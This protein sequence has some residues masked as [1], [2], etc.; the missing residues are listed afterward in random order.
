MNMADIRQLQ[1][2]SDYD[3][4]FVT[5]DTH[6]QF[7][8]L[9]LSAICAGIT[10]NDLLIILGDVGVNID[11]GERDTFAKAK[12]SQIQCDI[13]CIHGN[14]E[15]RPTTPDI[16]WKYQE[17]QWHDGIIYVEENYKRILFAKDGCRF[18]ING[19]EFLV[20]GGAYSV[21][22]KLRL[23]NGFPWFPD[24]Q[25]TDREKQ[26]IT[27]IVDAHGCKEDVILAHTCPYNYRPF[28]RL[29][30]EYSTSG[31]DTSMEQ[32]IQYVTE[33][34]DYRYNALYCGHWHINR[35][36]E[37]VHFLFDEIDGIAKTI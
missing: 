6:G 37:R 27:K 35:T 20:I 3:R 31:I 16:K 2:S 32:Y 24:E 18:N 25:L 4:I 8:Q 17:H 19:R 11:N 22:K 26:E 30:P 28:D 13:L 23:A 9:I 34:I 29:L 5:G 36:V 21:D 7:D 12:L 1:S 14:H 10:E 15:R 33:L